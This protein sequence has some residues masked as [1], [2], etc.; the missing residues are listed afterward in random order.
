MDVEF[1]DKWI[2]YNKRSSNIYDHMSTKKEGHNNGKNINDYERI[3]VIE[4]IMYSE[5]EPPSTF[6]YMGGCDK[7]GFPCMTENPNEAKRYSSLRY[8]S[9]LVR[10]LK[11]DLHNKLYPDEYEILYDIRPAIY[12]HNDICD[13]LFNYYNGEKTRSK[14][15]F[16]EDQILDLKQ[17]S[18]LFDIS[19]ARKERFGDD[20]DINELR[21][22]LQDIEL[23][24]LELRKDPEWEDPI[25][26]EE[27]V[28]PYIKNDY[29]PD[30]ALEDLF[31][32]RHNGG[33]IFDFELHKEFLPEGYIQIG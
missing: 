30:K 21:Q 31:M 18:I 15:M 8:T 14:D 24:R 5:E 1:E 6:Y 11:K 32:N 12:R 26:A 13:Y 7:D 22:Q 9:E 33:Q 2:K 10:E 4:F 28:K 16:F 3:Y 20:S 19:L 27:F 25:Y 29:N 17:G 23:E